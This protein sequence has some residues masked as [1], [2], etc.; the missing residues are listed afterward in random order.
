MKSSATMAENIYCSSLTY[1]GLTSNFDQWCQSTC[2]ADMGSLPGYC[3]DS[4]CTCSGILEQVSSDYCA[5]PR[6]CES[7]NY[8]ANPGTV[9]S[10]GWCNS[11][12]NAEPAN[13]P[14]SLCL[15]DG[16]CGSGQTE[17]VLNFDELTGVSPLP[18]GYK[19]FA[20][21]NAAYSM[22]GIEYGSGYANGVV[23]PSN[24]LFSGWADDVVMSRPSFRI[25]SAHFTSA[26]KSIDFT[27]EGKKGGVSVF[28]VSMSLNKDSPLF[29]E[30]ENLDLDELTFHSE[31]NYDEHFAIDDLAVCVPS[32][33]L[34]KR[35]ITHRVSRRNNDDRDPARDSHPL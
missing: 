14:C 32:G 1:K 8:V 6:V 17:V 5:S 7:G 31:G 22:N 2:N 19:G 4:F 20:W 25:L 30:F 18:N 26:W 29:Y 15:C 3:P 24:V 13:C 35:A 27:V 34:E 10:D 23:S 11:T 28:L 21:N 16:G 33:E 9:S 12:C